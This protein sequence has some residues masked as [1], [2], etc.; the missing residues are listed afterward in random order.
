MGSW[1]LVVLWMGIVV[2]LSS[3]P[4]SESREISKGVTEK[5]I[6]TVERVAPNR[7]ESIQI[8]DIHFYVRKNAHL[9]A[10]ALLGF[11][12]INAL[13]RSGVFGRKSIMIALFLCAF[14]AISDE[15][16]QVFVPGRSGEVRDVFIDILGASLGI[17]F[18]MMLFK[19]GLKMIKE[20][21]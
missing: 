10:Y 7:A 1:L 18:Y 19:V 13:R 2:F 14:F 6:E 8:S 9:F 11:L 12:L 16:H 17:L 20:K 15:I 4:A 5:V 21:Q 3:Q